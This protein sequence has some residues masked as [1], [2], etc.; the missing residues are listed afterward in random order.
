MI[1]LALISCSTEVEQFSN[2]PQLYSKVNVNEWISG[3]L[4]EAEQPNY[5]DNLIYNE[6]LDVTYEYK[7]EKDGKTKYFE[8]TSFGKW[9]FIDSITVNNNIGVKRIRVSAKNPDKDY[10]HQQQSTIKYELLN[11]NGETIGSASTG[12]IENYKNIVVHNPRDGFFLSL[13][14]FPWPTI[15]FPIK[16]NKTWEWKF[17]YDSKLYG[18]D[19]MYNWDGITEMIYTYKYLGEQTLNLEFGKIKTSKYEA[20]GTDGTILNRLIYY[21]NSEIGFVKQEFYTDN[22][23][24]I[25][26]TAVKYKNKCK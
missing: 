8:Q 25:N 11:S 26:L 14:S 23:A 18:D 13:F 21:F 7:Y 9:K 17:S 4:A 1:L 2:E 6:C 20:V 24:N 19:R 16:D 3:Y 22:G 10:S 15:K 12:V 5:D